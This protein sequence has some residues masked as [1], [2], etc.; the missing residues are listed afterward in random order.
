LVVTEAQAREIRDALN[1][2]AQKEHAQRQVDEANNLLVAETW[3]DG[4]KP[5]VPKTR[6]EAE[7]VINFIKS[8][9]SS[10]TDRFRL[11]IL[12]KKLELALIKLQ[13]RKRSG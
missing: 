6:V 5:D 12:P 8:L 7:N 3:W 11:Y 1:L 10:E 4:I 2:L 9:Q 13:E